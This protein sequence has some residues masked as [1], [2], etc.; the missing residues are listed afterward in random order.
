MSIGTIQK[1]TDRKAPLLQQEVQKE[2][3][4]G[5]SFQVEAGEREGQGEAKTRGI[6]ARGE[7]VRKKISQ[8]ALRMVSSLSL[9]LTSRRK[10]Y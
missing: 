6:A 5:L 2:M 1:E 8:M 4:Q 9:T 10:R 3:M 7:R